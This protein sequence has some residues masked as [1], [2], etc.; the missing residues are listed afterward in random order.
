MAS[1]WNSAVRSRSSESVSTSAPLSCMVFSSASAGQQVSTSIIPSIRLIKRFIIFIMIVSAP[2][3][4]GNDGLFDDK[5]TL[6]YFTAKIRRCTPLFG[7]ENVNFPQKF[8]R[9]RKK[10]GMQKSFPAFFP[11]FQAF[12]AVRLEENAAAVS[13]ATTTANMHQLSGA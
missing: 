8:S 11:V 10:E 4:V 7:G 9:F 6:S 2:F 5:P 12:S 13:Q 3:P 1:A